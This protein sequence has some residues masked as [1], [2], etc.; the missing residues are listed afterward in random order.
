MVRVRCWR[1]FVSPVRETLIRDQ[2]DDMLI[3][4]ERLETV[5]DLYVLRY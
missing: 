2:E 3:I 5:E 1:E 4:F